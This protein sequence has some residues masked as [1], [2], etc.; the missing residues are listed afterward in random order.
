[1]MPSAVS[2]AG[3]LLSVRAVRLV[4]VY[5]GLISRTVFRTVLT[6]ITDAD[7]IQ[8]KIGAVLSTEMCFLEEGILYA[9]LAAMSQ[10]RNC[11]R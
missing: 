6:V 1:M 2:A 9:G 3:A 11:K 4:I 8:I 7:S 5:G 10:G